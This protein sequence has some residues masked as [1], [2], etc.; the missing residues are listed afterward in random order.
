MVLLTLLMERAGG[1]SDEAV[2]RMEIR[3]EEGVT[4]CATGRR[5]RWR[6]R[7]GEKK[8]ESTNRGR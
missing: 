6:E 7:R 2:R 5:R 3:E 1:I 4:G 8:R